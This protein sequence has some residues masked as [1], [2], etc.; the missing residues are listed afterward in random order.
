MVVAVALILTDGVTVELTV[1]VIELEVAVVGLAHA[2][3]LVRTQVTIWPLVKVVVVNVE[4]L[5]PTL[6]PFTFH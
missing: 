5:V 4:L 1:I 6:V 2:E 3:L